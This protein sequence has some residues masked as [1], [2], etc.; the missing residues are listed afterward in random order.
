MIFD[1]PDSKL[2][3]NDRAHY[4]TKAKIRA[5]QKSAAFYITKS[6]G[7]KWP[8]PVAIDIIFHPPNKRHRDLDNLLAS[9]KGMIDGICEA[10]GI[11]DKNIHPIT[12]DWGDVV[13]GGRVEIKQ[14]GQ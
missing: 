4:Q 13:K 11:N 3:P 2:N 14:K 12:L 8:E 1:W 7:K 10:M 5:K 9:C 6:Y